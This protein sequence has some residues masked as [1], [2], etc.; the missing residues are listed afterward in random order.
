MKT[1]KFLLAFFLL[2]ILTLPTGNCLAEET[3]KFNNILAKKTSL[4]S[5]SPTFSR[6]K[7]VYAIAENKFY[8]S[9]DGGSTWEQK[10]LM[11]SSS[12]S[13]ETITIYD[14]IDNPEGILF[15]YG[16][17]FR[18]STNKSES[19]LLQSK[20]GG[21]TWNNITYSGDYRVAV[22]GSRNI[23]RVY[24]KCF[25]SSIDGGSNWQKLKE[26]SSSNI[27]AVQLTD[28]DKTVYIIY[29]PSNVL[30][31]DIYT[32]GAWRHVDFGAD[33]KIAK[34]KITC[35]T[36][37]PGGLFLLGTSNNYVLISKDYGKT[38]SINGEGITSSISSV[39]CAANTDSVDIFAATAKGLFYLDYP[40]NAAPAKTDT[41]KKSQIK[42][43]IGNRSYTVDSNVKQM[44]AEPFI[45][46][47]RVFVPVKCLGEALGAQVA[48][49]AGNN[50]ITVQNESTKV[51]L[52]INTK[53]IS[54]NNQVKDLD[55]SP[56]IRDDRSYL[57]AAYVAEAFGYAVDW[58]AKTNTVNI[59]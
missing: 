31:A 15:L 35:A 8:R 24:D 13:D 29:N 27:K 38:W 58:D 12:Y 37:A 36:G 22:T 5:I 42:F 49:D 21:T 45:E 46:Q 4:V 34:S 44:D 28:N 3:N 26:Y 7:S 50:T 59:H 11:F 40:L 51:L 32:N 41:P 10:N 16:S 56:I 25:W 52:T 54:I 17:K 39:K 43:V 30:D 55:V 18:K 14:M 1:G 47:D 53:K 23:I 6:D 19:F 57:P 2:L 9:L 20:D 48:W 33:S